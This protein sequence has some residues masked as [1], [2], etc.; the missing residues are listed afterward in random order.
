M[1]LKQQPAWWDHVWTGLGELLTAWWPGQESLEEQVQARLDALRPRPV[2]NPHVV[3]PAAT[4][5]IDD[6]WRQV[7]NHMRAAMAQVDRSL[8]A[9]QRRQVRRWSRHR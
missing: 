2:S 5:A 9:E 7:G 4:A 1:N 3:A 8:T 6:A